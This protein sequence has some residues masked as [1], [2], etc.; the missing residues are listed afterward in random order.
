MSE[1]S[2]EWH[3]LDAS[4]GNFGL[5]FATLLPLRI[6]RILTLTIPAKTTPASFPNL[7]DIFIVR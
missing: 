5:A 6:E 7:Q 1:I 2:S 4:G 3:P